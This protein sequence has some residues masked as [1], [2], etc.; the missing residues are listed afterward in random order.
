[1]WAKVVV[2]PPGGFERWLE[3]A[4]NFLKTLPPAEAGQRLAVTRGCAQCHSVDGTAGTGP[5]WKGLF[6]SHVPLQGGRVMTADEDYIRNCILDPTKNVPLGFQP[7]MPTF[8]GRIR[9]D[10]ITAIIAYI[11]SLK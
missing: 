11:K 2:H 9:D 5:T 6:G 8:K 7:V 3:Q 10:E 1:M 4:S